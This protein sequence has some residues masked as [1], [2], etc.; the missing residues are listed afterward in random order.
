M[1]IQRCTVAHAT[2]KTNVPLCYRLSAAR[3]FLL[4]R[5]VPA[6]LWLAYVHSHFIPPPGFPETKAN[7]V[8][9]DGCHYT[10]SKA[11]WFLCI[12]LCDLVVMFIRC[13]LYSDNKAGIMLLQPSLVIWL[14]GYR[15]LVC[16]QVVK[17]NMFYSSRRKYLSR[18]GNPDS[19]IKFCCIA[20]TPSLYF[21]VKHQLL[22]FFNHTQALPHL[23]RTIKFKRPGHPLRQQ[24]QSRTDAI[25][26]AKFISPNFLL[27]S[28]HKKRV[29]S[30]A[31]LALTNGYIHTHTQKRIGQRG[32][33][34][35][36]AA[37]ARSL[38]YE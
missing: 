24:L 15:T 1:L 32:R 8:L 5:S 35:S 21:D 10:S 19:S 20:K 12:L 28:A 9:L 16:F 14:K 22:Q 2:R 17:M 27:T 34:V 7:I 18:C 33:Q 4:R 23:H 31:R 11:K 25:E 26:A 36:A 30:R 13:G 29:K 38:V 37:V 3:A 6:G